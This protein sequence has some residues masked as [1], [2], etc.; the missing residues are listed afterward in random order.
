MSSSVVR[1]DAR[2]VAVPLSWFPRLDYASPEQRGHWR[3]IGL[4]EGIH[5]LDVDEDISVS[6]LLRLGPDIHVG[7]VTVDDD[8][9]TVGLRDG[10]QIAVPLV[11]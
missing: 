4:G 11:W 2:E 10:R 6:S 7:S 3:M 9:L 1:P 8:A 5:W